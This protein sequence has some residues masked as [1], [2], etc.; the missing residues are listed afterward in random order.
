MTDDRIAWLKE[1]KAGIGGSDVAAV[2]GI[3]PYRTPLD[4]YLDKTNPN[5]EDK[6]ISDSAYWGTLLEDQVANE[7]SRRTGM[8]V[9]RVNQSLQQNFMH[10]LTHMQGWT[11]LPTN[12]A[13]ANIDRA[14]INPNLAKTVRIAKPGS[15]FESKGL[16]LTTDTIL[17]C[18]TASLRMSTEWG[19]SQE[20]EIV[21]GNV[22]SEHEIPMY[23][24]TQ[25][26]WYMAITGAKTAYV[27][28]LIGGQDFRI[29]K[30]D[31]DEDLIQTIIERCAD[32]W[33]NHVLAGV[34]P[35]ATSA[36][37]VR[38]LY[39]KDDGELEEATN[40]QAAD[41]GELRNL[42]AQIKEL[43]DQEKAVASKVIAAIGPHLGLTIGGKKAVTYKHQVTRRLS[44]S[45]L[46]EARPEIYNAFLKE[47]ETR[48][49]RLAA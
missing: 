36:A 21:A 20:E 34:P 43:Q 30:V 18:K 39:Q 38:K 13:R 48:V 44:S 6:P 23:Y 40:E 33:L 3:N 15:K 31:R 24:E 47:S 28:V 25:V 9:Q 45:E 8:K 26:Q 49:L 10:K 42:R 37:D 19:P 41:I 7:F 5:V 1:R 16:V 46:K 29:Y 22:E 17:E 2:L 32:F 27:A 12:W 35:E 14:V 11:N 4:V